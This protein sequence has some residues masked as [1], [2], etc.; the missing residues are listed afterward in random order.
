MRAPRLTAVLGLLLATAV[1]I[2]ASGIGSARADESLPPAAR[3]ELVAIFA[4]KVKPFGLRVTRAASIGPRAAPI[5]D[6]APV[7]MM[8]APSISTPFPLLS[9]SRARSVTTPGWMK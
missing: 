3:K 4:K 5:P 6:D 2:G 1:V 9:R 7:T 8:F